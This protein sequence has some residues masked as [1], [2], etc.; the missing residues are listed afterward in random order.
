L[1]ETIKCETKN[2]NPRNKK[3]IM[4]PTRF[5]MFGW[6]FVPNWGVCVEVA[7][8]DFWSA[9]YS[10]AAEMVARFMDSIVR[11]QEKSRNSVGS[12]SILIRISGSYASD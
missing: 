11:Y 6:W 12:L 2:L 9:F 7:G 3:K 4:V 1:T 8:G 10:N 5:Y